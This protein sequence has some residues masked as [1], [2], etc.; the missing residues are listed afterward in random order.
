[1]FQG[2]LDIFVCFFFVRPIIDD[3]F[4]DDVINHS[5]RVQC[6]LCAIAVILI[7]IIVITYYYYALYAKQIHRQITAVIG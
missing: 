2:R 4:V 3:G 7:N 5:S 1:M 6:V